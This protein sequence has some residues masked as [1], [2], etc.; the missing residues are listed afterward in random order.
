MTESEIEELRRE[1]DDARAVAIDFLAD[2]EA[3]GDYQFVK[4]H[5]ETVTSREWLAPHNPFP[6]GS[7]YFP[8]TLPKEDNEG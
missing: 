8:D 3:M 1:R 4:W 2:L 7:P 5:W 6:Q